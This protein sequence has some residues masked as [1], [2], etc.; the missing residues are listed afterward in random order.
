MK[1]DKP[2]VSER[3]QPAAFSITIE[4]ILYHSRKTQGVEHGSEWEMDIEVHQRLLPGR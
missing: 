3:I 4:D 2:A 1:L